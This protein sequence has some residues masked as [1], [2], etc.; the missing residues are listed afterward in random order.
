MKSVR[1]WLVLTNGEELRVVKRRPQLSA[2]EVAIEINIKVPQ[3]PRVIGTIDMEL[4]EP[5]AVL[6]DSTVT[7]YPE[8]QE[9]AS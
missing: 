1:A 6:V 2:N 3:P 4:P 9:E 7:Q 5:P 8:L